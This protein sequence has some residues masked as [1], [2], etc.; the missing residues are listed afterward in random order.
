MSYKL[1]ELY[2]RII[3]IPEV[4]FKKVFLKISQETPLRESLFQ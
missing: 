4:F 3:K 2:V 1:V